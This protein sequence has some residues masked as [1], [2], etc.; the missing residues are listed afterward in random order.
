MSFHISK[1]LKD[2]NNS[3]L[4]GV[5]RGCQMM[6]NWSRNSVASHIRATCPAASP[7][8]KK[9]FAKRQFD[10]DTDGDNPVKLKKRLEIDGDLTLLTDD[11]IDEISLKIESFFFR[12]GI[13]FRVAD[14]EAFKEMIKSLNPA[15]GSS[16]PSS[17]SLAGPLLDRQYRKCS[18][19]LKEILDGTEH[20]TLISN[21]W[22]NTRGDHLVNFC[23]RTPDQRPFFYTQIDT[24]DMKDNSEAIANAIIDIIKQLGPF[25]FS[26]VITDNTSLMRPSWKFIE[27]RYPHISVIG[28]VARE[29]NPLLIA[30]LKTPEFSRIISEA[31]N[32]IN[33][34]ITQNIVK[35]M[36]EEK[37][38][39]EGVSN[40]LS[41]PVSTSCLSVVNSMS[42]LL[43]SKY[44][45]HRLV[46][47]E[48][49]SLKEIVPKQLLIAVI[50][51]ISSDN[52]W[53][54]LAKL[55]QH[56]EYPSNTIGKKLVCLFSISN[57]LFSNFFR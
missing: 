52:F 16:M 12:T 38:I 19:M 30:I 15:Y 18:A 25:K 28:C 54:D 55:L 36:Y 14:S 51:T 2:F 34:I 8:E 5:C 4:Q 31:E 13:P 17:E 23:V 26:S 20:C 43:A 42:D 32:V 1:Y 40:I 57:N 35:T 49:H 33:F 29:V 56:I 50:K 6:I 44:V 47:E 24:S 53:H 9:K 3:T 10:E 39:S 46:D 11:K 48:G 22:S 45:L 41:L 21:G 37:R 7:E 27:K